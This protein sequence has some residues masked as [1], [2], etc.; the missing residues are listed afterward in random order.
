MIRIQ[1]LLIACLVLTGCKS[2]SVGTVGPFGFSDEF[3]SSVG[4]QAPAVA[5]RQMPQE[6][7]PQHAHPLFNDPRFDWWDKERME[8]AVAG[9]YPVIEDYTYK[10]VGRVEHVLAYTQSGDQGY[11]IVTAF[12]SEY[13]KPTG[14]T[15]ICSMNWDR[16]N[17][18][19][20]KKTV[21][22]KLAEMFPSS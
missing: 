12:I 6:Q 8:E 4:V 16:R 18:R 11:F 14:R 21:E 2:V 7:E 10:D 13:D 9:E 20:F 1:V 17:D 19:Y 22:E 3:L 5:V 15:S